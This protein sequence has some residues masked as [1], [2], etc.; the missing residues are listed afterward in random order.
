MVDSDYVKHFPKVS[1]SSCQTPS[2]RRNERTSRHQKSNLVHFSLK[3]WHMVAI[4][5][6]IFMTINWTNFV[7]LLVDPGFFPPPPS[8]S[9]KHRGL[10]RMGWTP[11]TGT[12]DRDASLCPL[13]CLSVSLCLRWSL[14]HPHL[15]LPSH[16]P[17]SFLRLL[18]CFNILY[19]SV[20]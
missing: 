7:Y 20:F 10:F 9:T 13:V 8:V 19:F 14:T 11:L 6:T 12:T 3:M 18:R 15:I 5:L 1:S 4:I 17:Q 16:V 2:K